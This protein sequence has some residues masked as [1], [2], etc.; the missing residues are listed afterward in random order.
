M[1]SLALLKKGL[2]SRVAASEIYGFEGEG[3]I[4]KSA[5]AKLFKRFED[6]N[7]NVEDLPRSGRPLV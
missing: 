5:E 2:S 4:R 7:L 6:V 3:A 1:N